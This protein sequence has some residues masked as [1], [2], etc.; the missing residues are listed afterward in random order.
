MIN[1]FDIMECKLVNTNIPNES[2]NASISLFD[3]AYRTNTVC[4]DMV[5][6]TIMWSM[7]MVQKTINIHFLSFLYLNYASFIWIICLK[8]RIRTS[9]NMIDNKKNFNAPSLYDWV[10]PPANHIFLK[11]LFWYRLISSMSEI[12]VLLRL[13][14]MFYCT[15]ALYSTSIDSCYPNSYIIFNAFNEFSYHSFFTSMVQAAY[16][17]SIIKE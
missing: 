6:F 10:S 4:R 7:N 9:Y 8:I 2:L 3:D 14:L 11:Y 5:R 12:S 17:I 16:A 1:S 15:M 13:S